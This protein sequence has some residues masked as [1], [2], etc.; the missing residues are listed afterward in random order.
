MSCNSPAKIHT[1]GR[2][3]EGNNP[4]ED[5]HG[6]QRTIHYIATGDS[7]RRTNKQETTSPW[8]A[9]RSWVCHH[10]ETRDHWSKA[11]KKTQ[12]TGEPNLFQA[13]PAPARNT[14]NRPACCESI[15]LPF[16]R[17]RLCLLFCKTQERQKVGF[18]ARRRHVFNTRSHPAIGENP[19]GQLE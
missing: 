16:G 19:A 18:V 2:G 11:V 9:D 14:S 15:R 3:E 12:R 13:P 10:C 4:T 6:G 17:A 7:K 5:N 8:H 1:W